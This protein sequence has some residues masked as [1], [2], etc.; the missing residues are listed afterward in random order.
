MRFSSKYVALAYDYDSSED[1]SWRNKWEGGRIME[2]WNY[3]I[4]ELWD[5][6]IVGGGKS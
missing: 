3:G 6:G 5:Y 4:A 1:F 2:L